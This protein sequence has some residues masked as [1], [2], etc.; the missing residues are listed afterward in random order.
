MP[1]ICNRPLCFLFLVCSSSLVSCGERED[2]DEEREGGTVE[3]TAR[4]AE[5]SMIA[6]GLKTAG[7]FA[8]KLLTMP[9]KTSGGISNGVG[10]GGGRNISPGFVV[11]ND[12]ADP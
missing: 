2:D 5:E 7:Y 9:S 3:N 4:G 12:R 11:M 1:K 8:C 6:R 10:G